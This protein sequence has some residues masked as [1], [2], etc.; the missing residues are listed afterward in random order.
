MTD[1]DREAAELID[2]SVSRWQPYP[3]YKDSGVEWL[4]AIP[5]HWMTEKLKFNTYIKGRVG[6]ENLRASEFTDEGPYLVTGM[7]FAEG[8]IDWESCYHV[9]EER[10]Q[11]APEIHLRERDVLI[12]KDGS[13][14]KLAYIDVLPGKA[15]LNS[16]L[17]VLRPLK[18]IYLPRFLYHLLGSSIFKEYVLIKQSGTTFYGITQEAIANFPILLPSLPE[19]RAITAFL[20]RETAE[21]D[22]LIAKKRELIALLQEQRS[23][24]ISHAVTKGLNP[25]TPMKDSGI[26]WL[27]KI[28]AHWGIVPVKYTLTNYE[29]GIS[30]S[31]SDI[32]RY[33]VLTMGHVQDGKLVIP[34]EGCLEEKPDIILQHHDLIFNRTNSLELVGKVGLFEGS[35]EDEISIA[36]YLVRLRPNAATS[37]IY[38]NYLLNCHWMLAEAQSRALRS[39]NQANLNPSRYTNIKIPFPPLLEQL[40]IADYL[41]S[42]CLHIEDL[43]GKAQE[44]VVRLQEYRTAMISAAVTGKIDVRGKRKYD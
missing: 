18:G 1:L 33:K 12:T 24:I 38:L 29:Y 42:Q 16:H 27:G 26:E 15:T 31:L 39:I 8:G 21:I 36:S 40:M 6:W 22:A 10:Y 23:A 9:S 44:T 3:E 7:H 14:G 5:A 13:I 2:S 35:E 30:A 28:P 19:Q 11:I 17:L 41:Q 4:G 37:P 43:I 32:G 25:N 20:D 34:D